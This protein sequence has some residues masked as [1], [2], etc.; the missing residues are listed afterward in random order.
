MIVGVDVGGTFTDV[1]AF[2]P[3]TGRVGAGKVPSTPGKFA[4]GFLGGIERLGIK[5]FD[6]TRLLHG[7]TV[8]TNT[9]IERNGARTAGVFTKGFRDALAIGTGQRFTG[10]LFEPAFRR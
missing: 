1:V 4:E 3:A 7:T 6:V 8:A 5:P 10:G 2:D 9:A